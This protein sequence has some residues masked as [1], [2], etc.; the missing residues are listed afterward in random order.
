MNW[1]WLLRAEREEGCVPLPSS[2]VMEKSSFW[3]DT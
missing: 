1:E 3:G 2:V